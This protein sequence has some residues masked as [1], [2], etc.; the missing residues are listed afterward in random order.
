MLHQCSFG[1]HICGHTWEGGNIA[2]TNFHSEKFELNFPAVQWNKGIINPFFF[3][4]ESY[5][6]PLKWAKR[7]QLNKDYKAISACLPSASC[8]CGGFDLARH[9]PTLTWFD[10]LSLPLFPNMNRLLLAFALHD[11]ISAVEDFWS[12]KK[13][14]C[15]KTGTK[16]E[17]IYRIYTGWSWCKGV[18]LINTLLFWPR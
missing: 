1:F 16:S 11:I 17:S 5:S 14:T 3:L 12:A 9:T 8:D 2:F 7:L 18:T 13:R 10:L 4:R 15:G 6:I